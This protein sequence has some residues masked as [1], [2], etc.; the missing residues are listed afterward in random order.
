M[1]KLILLLIIHI[2]FYLSSCVGLKSTPNPLSKIKN[3]TLVNVP[4]LER[5]RMYP[6]I[7]TR[8]QGQNAQVFIRGISAVNTPKEVLFIVNGNQ[9]GSFSR[10]FFSLNS[11]EITDIRLLKK[12]TEI[13]AYGF[14]G[15][16]GVVLISTKQ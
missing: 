14:A 11:V 3:E 10:T 12:A 6:G 7:V 1:K 4:L 15:S 2:F 13:A 5:L 16:G 9:T 8:G